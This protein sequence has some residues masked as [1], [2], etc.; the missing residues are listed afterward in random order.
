MCCFSCSIRML[1]ISD[2]VEKSFRVKANAFLGTNRSFACSRVPYCVFPD[3]SALC[4]VFVRVQGHFTSSLRPHSGDSI[5]PSFFLLMPKH[6]GKLYYFP[7][8]FPLYTHS[9]VLWLL[10]HAHLT[11]LS[12]S[13]WALPLL[14]CYKKRIHG[15]MIAICSIVVREGEGRRGL[16]RS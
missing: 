5:F 6:E 13:A 9:H 16:I 12:R 15:N 7:P 11:L 8:F 14:S 4:R 10:S 3:T 2:E 1:R